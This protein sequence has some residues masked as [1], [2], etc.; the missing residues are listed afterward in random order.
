MRFSYHS[1]TDSLYIHLTEQP[2][3]DV[4]A[5]SDD[6][7]LD[8]NADGEL[9]GIEIQNASRHIDLSV[10]EIGSLPLKNLI[11]APPQAA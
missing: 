2:G 9:V 5:V 8:M 6:I 10:L 1:E 7:V 4:H 11:F 3:A